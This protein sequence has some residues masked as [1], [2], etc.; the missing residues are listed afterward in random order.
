[1]QSRDQCQRAIK[2]S[3]VFLKGKCFGCV[4]ASA[5]FGLQKNDASPTAHY[6]LVKSWAWAR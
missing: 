3:D 5:A 1:M 2:D 6:I 4:W